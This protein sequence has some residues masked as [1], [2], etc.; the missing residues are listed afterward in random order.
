VRSA[1]T[2]HLN[3]VFRAFGAI[4]ARRMFGG[5]GIYHEGVMIGLVIDETLYLKTDA[6][7]HERF[8]DVGAEPFRYEKRGETVVTSYYSMPV[9]AFDD[10]DLARS[11]ASVAYEAALRTRQRAPKRK[12]KSAKAD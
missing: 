4:D 1:F 7:T 8:Q 10:P 3:E 5:Y 6:D 12:R 9:D 11:W 2:E